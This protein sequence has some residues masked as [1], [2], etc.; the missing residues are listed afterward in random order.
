MK[1]TD[2]LIALTAVF[3]I[4]FVNIFSFSA[5][6]AGVKYSASSASGYT[7]ETV[8]ISVTASASNVWGCVVSL[9][10]N[11]SE[12]KCVSCAKG[13]IATSGSVN[14]NGSRVTF[15]GQIAGSGGG[16]IFTA[17][18]KILKASGTCALTVSASGGGDNCDSDGNP[19]SF[20][21][22]GGK[23]TVKEKATSTTA[24][25]TTKAETTTRAETTK[26]ETTTQG[27]PV[28]SI[29]LNKTS[30]SLK[31]NE[32]ASLS[33]TVLPS[34]ATN[35]T[36]S[37][38]SSD[39]SVVKVSSSGKVTAVGGGTATVTATAGGKSTTCK[40]SV[41][42]KQTGITHQGSSTKEVAV[43]QTLNL[44]VEKVP[45]D[46]TDKYI[47]T[48]KSADTPVATISDGGVVTGVKE[49][50]AVITAES[51]GWKI[52]Y[53]INVIADSEEET[54]EETSAEA[55]VPETTDIPATTEITTEMPSLEDEGNIFT[56][57]F[58]M[59]PENGD[60]NNKSQIIFAVLI[61]IAII[62]A[63]AVVVTIL[64]AVN[65]KNNKDKSKDPEGP[66]DK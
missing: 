15:A 56:K 14:N 60:T 62:L 32:T 11:S 57:I 2:K 35:K 33:A 48:W 22:S 64:V 30:I 28:A 23:V 47:T 17:T 39:K 20:S 18:F 51:N 21:T 6:A 27:I 61:A 12:L 4:L 65:I 53:T 59:I 31:K 26:Q 19:V 37:Y 49:G 41:V 16:T 45:S 43:G 66:E 44:K 7:G 50:S 34:N 42:S 52:Q 63:V 25:S 46:A 40:V 58:N 54:S 29:S 55:T 36:V 1:K 13:G 3:L 10:Y 9:G 5:S 38:R 24:V 8:T